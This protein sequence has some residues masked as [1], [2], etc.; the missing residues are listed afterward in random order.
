MY[1][2]QVSKK[3]ARRRLAITKEECCARFYKGGLRPICPGKT[4]E[5]LSVALWKA[6]E[7]N[8]GL[9][10]RKVVSPHTL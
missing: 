8:G 4:L 3:E 10:I 9:Q 7:V 1:Y 5:C 6:R 2:D